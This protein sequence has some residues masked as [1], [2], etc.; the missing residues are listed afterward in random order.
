MS[1][2]KLIIIVAAV[3]MVFVGC[4]I[5]GVAFVSAGGSFRA[6]STDSF[7]QRE[8][9]IDGYFDSVNIRLN[10]TD[11]RIEPARDGNCIIESNL[12]EKVGLHA[13]V[14]GGELVIYESDGRRW[15]DHISL[16]SFEGSWM[17]VY[18]P[19]TVYDSLYINV[20]TS[21][22][23]INGGLTFDLAKI[24]LSTGDL[25]CRANIQKSLSVDT[26]SGDLT[27][28]GLDGTDTVTVK[29]NTG[30]IEITDLQNC[31][32]VQAKVSS[33]SV[34]LERV[35]AQTVT[36]SGRTSDIELNNVI[37]AGLLDVSTSSGDIEFARCDGREVVLKTSTGDIEGSFIS[38]K[39]FDAHA[40]TGNVRVPASDRSGGLCKVKTSSGDIKITVK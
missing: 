14:S 20:S 37:S 19:Q 12:S 3:V 31:G 13:E 36:V 32:S 8:V 17:V 38:G 28:S 29:T 2:T 22:I 34:E 26:S 24:D 21:D 30:D 33:G 23:V 27:L 25:E 7:V 35:A 4:I 15:Y 6:M 9:R 39:M 18:L 5:M 40:S 1:K 10:T 11:L 16:F